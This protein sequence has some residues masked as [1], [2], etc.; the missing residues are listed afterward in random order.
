M[1]L[2]ICGVSKIIDF[3]KGLFLDITIYVIRYVVSTKGERKEKTP[4]TTTEKNTHKNLK[5]K[6]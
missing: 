4:Q 3:D 5:T 1:N 6:E 2:L